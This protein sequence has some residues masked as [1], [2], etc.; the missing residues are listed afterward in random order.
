MFL[1]ED[2]Q[3]KYK[4]ED[5]CH[6]DFHLAVVTRLEEETEMLDAVKK[7]PHVTSFHR[8]KIIE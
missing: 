1:S 2:E 6:S 3:K 8:I 7:V 4:L 5:G